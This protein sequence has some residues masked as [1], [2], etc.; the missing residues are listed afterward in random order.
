MAKTRDTLYKGNNR[1][2]ARDY[3]KELNKVLEAGMIF[4]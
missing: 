3:T 1:L 2:R 4:E